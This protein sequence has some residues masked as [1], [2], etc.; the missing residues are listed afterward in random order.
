MGTEN[1]PAR[2]ANGLFWVVATENADGTVTLDSTGMVGNGRAELSLVV[3]PRLASVASL[4][5]FADGAL[6]IQPGTI[7]DGYDSGASE[8]E[9]AVKSGIGGGGL[10][11]LGLGGLTGPAPEPLGKL[12]ANGPIQASGTKAAPT[13][14]DGDLTPGPGR[15]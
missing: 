6:A 5:V 13:V 2:F 3:E 1:L 14:I 4:G 15:P 12:G 8:Y 7:V 10:G 11:G 9:K